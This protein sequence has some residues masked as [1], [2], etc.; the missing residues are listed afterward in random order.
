MHVAISL[1]QTLV[2]IFEC[3]TIELALFFLL[4]GTQI[5]FVDC[6]V[7]SNHPPAREFIF[8]QIRAS[9]PMQA[10]I[11]INSLKIDSVETCLN[12]TTVCKS[13]T[14]TENDDRI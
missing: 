8:R 13:N 11:I 4:K 5:D 10:S 2:Y 3:Y 12:K 1:N 14:K 6:H 9:H 7:C